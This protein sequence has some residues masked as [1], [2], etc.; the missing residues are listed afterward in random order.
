MAISIS[1]CD[2]YD[3]IYPKA[4]LNVSNGS[5][6]SITAIYV[7]SETSSD[8][9]GNRISDEIGQGYS[10]V[11]DGVE[12]GRIKVKVQFSNGAQVVKENIDLSEVEV[13]ELSVM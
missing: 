13:Y 12:K 4:S 10:V 1:S 11:I 8:W 2:M 7:T 3:L 5:A 9:G 6:L